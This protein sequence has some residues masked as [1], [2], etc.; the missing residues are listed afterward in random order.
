MIDTISVTTK[1]K[2]SIDKRVDRELIA[3]ILTSESIEQWNSTREI[4]KEFR[5]TEWISAHIDASGLIGKTKIA[6]K[7]CE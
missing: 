5:S 6:S 7:P 4:I 3:L 1:N 2:E